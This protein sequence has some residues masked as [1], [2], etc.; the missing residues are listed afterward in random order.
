MTVL[1]ASEVVFY[2]EIPESWTMQKYRDFET[3]KSNRS[4]TWRVAPPEEHENAAGFGRPSG[5]D[6]RCL[7]IPGFRCASPW[8]IFLRSLRELKARIHHG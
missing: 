3:P 5:T 2:S 4:H 7:P 6:S 1:L 8:A